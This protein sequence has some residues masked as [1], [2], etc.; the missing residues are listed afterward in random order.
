MKRLSEPQ[1]T[2]GSAVWH[3]RQATY[4]SCKTKTNSYSQSELYRAYKVKLMVR[5]SLKL[6][7]RHCHRLNL[8]PFLHRISKC[9]LYLLRCPK[10]LAR[11]SLHE[12]LTAAPTNTPCFR[13][14]RRS[15]VLP[16]KEGLA[17]QNCT[18]YI[19]KAKLIIKSRSDFLN[20][21]L[22]IVHCTFQKRSL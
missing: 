21:T 14:R 18:L 5:L 13:H 6:A 8:P 19:P 17:S 20:C 1:K 15:C 11:C 16:S 4:T 3:C 10:F 9:S 22:Y 2:E 12:I 7:Y